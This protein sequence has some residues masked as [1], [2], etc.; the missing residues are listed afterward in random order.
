VE[1]IPDKINCVTLHLVGYTLEY[2]SDFVKLYRKI[3]VKY[4]FRSNMA[5]TVQNLKILGIGKRKYVNVS[6]AEVKDSRRRNLFTPLRK[7]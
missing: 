1:Q 4:H 5:F 7:V 2:F 3:R 6:Y